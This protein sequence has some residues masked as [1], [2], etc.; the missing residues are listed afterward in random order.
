MR[1]ASTGRRGNASCR[2]IFDFS[3]ESCVA[4]TSDTACCR[5][6]PSSRSATDA[7]ASS[8]RF[9]VGSS[10]SRSFGTIHQRARDRDP[11]LLADRELMRIGV[12]ALVDA[13]SASSIDVGRR[14]VD[15]QPGDAL[16]DQQVLHRGQASAAD[17]TAA[18][19]CR[20]AARGSGRARAGRAPTD[21]ARRRRP[22][23]CVG[24]SRPAIRCSSVVLPQPEG[25]TT[26]MLLSG[27]RTNSSSRST[28]SPPL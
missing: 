26:R 5:V 23:R 22:S 18:A 15:R 8:S 13:Q 9:D 2:G 19:R 16:R 3:R 10:A 28:S 21:P 11:L 27:S 12:D 6:A 4:M 14:A 24:S 20:C 17:G 1:L 25:P 7:Q